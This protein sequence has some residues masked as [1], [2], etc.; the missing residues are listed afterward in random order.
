MKKIKLALLGLFLAVPSFGV[1]ISL[2]N[3]VVKG[4]QASNSIGYVD[5]E[6]VFANHPLTKRMQEEFNSEVAKRKKAVSD[7]QAAI[8]SMNASVKS[9]ST[10][11]MQMK[12]ELETLKSNLNSPVN[13]VVSSFTAVAASTVAAVTGADVAAKEQSIRASEADIENMKLAIAKKEQELCDFSNQCKTEISDLEKK[14][15]D[16]VLADIYGILE[17]ITVED[18]LSMIVDK[19]NVLYGHPAQDYTDKVLERLQGR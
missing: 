7:L 12:V 14:Q 2:D 10:L 15:T 18:N 5:I 6:K 19:T 13:A 9:S 11:V 3:F 4:N 17:K 8:D 1:E 16:A